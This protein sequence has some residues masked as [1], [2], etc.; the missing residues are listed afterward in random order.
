M[1]QGIYAAWITVTYFIS[2]AAPYLI[3]L[4]LVILAVW[5]L[6]KHGEGR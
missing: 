1:I 5:Q 2:L 3:G 6:R 4:G